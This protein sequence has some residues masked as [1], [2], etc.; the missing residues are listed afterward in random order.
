MQAPAAGR[1]Q[2]RDA[3]LVSMTC[4][5]GHASTYSLVFILFFF[6]RFAAPDL[7]RGL[8]LRVRWRAVMAIC[9]RPTIACATCTRLRH[10]YIYN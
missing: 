4:R 10:C 6:I 1:L 9:S 7:A 5:G 2:Q 3:A 8:G